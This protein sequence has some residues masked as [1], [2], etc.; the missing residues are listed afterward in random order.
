MPEAGAEGG[1]AAL[2]ELISRH[3]GRYA[4]LMARLDPEVARAY[5]VR[6]AGA[7]AA[8]AC[9]AAREACSLVSLSSSLAEGLPRAAPQARCQEA[10]RAGGGTA[11]GTWTVPGAIVDEDAFRRRVATAELVAPATSTGR[12]GPT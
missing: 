8:G 10:T 5:Q 1:A 11:L 2:A 12:L 6:M 4:E 7:G 9:A 3:E